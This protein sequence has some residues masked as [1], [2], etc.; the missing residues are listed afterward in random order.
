MTC[1]ASPPA[2]T[3]APSSTCRRRPRSCA[4]SASASPTANRSPSRSSTSTPIASTASPRRSATTRRSTNSSATNYG[5][6]LASA[7]ETIEAVIAEGREAGLLKCQPGMPLLMLSS[8]HPGHQR[9]AHGVRSFALPRR[10]LPLPNGAAAS[11][12]LGRHPRAARRSCRFDSR[13]RT[14]PT[15][16]RPSS[17]RRGVA[18]TAA[19]S[20]T[21]SSTPCT[22]PT[23]RAGCATWSRTPPRARSSPRKNGR[24]LGFTRFGDETDN[25]SRGHVFALYVDPSAGGNGRGPAA[26]RTRDRA[27]SIQCRRGTSHC[28][29]LKRTTEPARFYE[30]AGFVPEGARRVEELYRAQEI[31]LTRRAARAPRRRR[32]TP[33]STRPSPRL[34]HERARGAAPA[35]RTDPLA[36]VERFGA[37][38]N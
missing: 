24:V 6:E 38:T 36:H 7:E 16:W 21:P 35:D 5:V 9:T 31:S 19:W 14:T 33:Q 20:T 1:V 11:A 8:T 34:V 10:P 28:G 17:S 27:S 32:S 15:N 22:T 29:S 23:S 13:A 37:P 18:P 26:A 30:A 4:S 3:W 2:S 12:H 25:P